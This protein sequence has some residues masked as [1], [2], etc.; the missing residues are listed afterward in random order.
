MLLTNVL[1]SFPFKVLFSSVTSLAIS[2]GGYRKNSLSLS[3]AITAVVV[4][5]TLTLAN[6]CFFSSLLAFFI[7]SSYWTKWESARKK[8]FEND[9]K[10]GT[11]FNKI[12]V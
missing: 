9:F 5:F 1:L 10:E 2:A 11:V 4:G 8:K 7:S 6:Y 12:F 3:G